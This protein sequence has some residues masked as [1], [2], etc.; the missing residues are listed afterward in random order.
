M[1]V[2]AALA[3]IL[4]AALAIAPSQAQFAG[5]GFVNG[6]V[7]FPA[8]DQ[9][10]CNFVLPTTFT[11]TWYV[12][13]SS[14]GQTQNAMTTAGISLNPTVTPHQGDAAHPWSSLQAVFST[15]T[16]Y[17][18]SLLSTAVG[19]TSASP[20]KPGDEILVNTGAGYGAVV[21]GGFSFTVNNPSYV[22][23]AA[24]PGQTPT[25]SSLSILNSTNLAFVGL[26]V[27]GGPT[28]TMVTIGENVGTTNNIVLDHLNVFT[29]SA[30]TAATYTTAAQ[31]IANVGSALGVSFSAGTCIELSN[32]HIFNVLNGMAMQRVQGLLIYNNEI[33]HWGEDAIDY[34]SYKIIISS[35]YLHD[36]ALYDTIN[37]VHSDFMQGFSSSQNPSNG[38]I[39]IDRNTEIY[40]TDPNLPFVGV[41]A[42]CNG[43][44]TVTNDQWAHLYVTNNLISVGPFPNSLGI[45]G[46][47]D[48]IIANNTVVGILEITGNDFAS[49]Q[50]KVASNI[51][52]KNNLSSGLTCAFPQAQMTNNVIM[53]GITNNT[54]CF[55]GTQTGNISAAGTYI[56]GNI[57]DSGGQASEL[58]DVDPVALIYNFHLLST[59]PAR[60]AGTSTLP[61]PVFDN[62]GHTVN[63]PPDAG[64]VA[65]P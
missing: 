42:C 40:Q 7:N 50:I 28:T 38:D 29:V 59:A 22:V 24:A 8:P 37:G 55:N 62:F 48:C 19:G 60:G 13:S 31:W 2:R 32:S 65:Y 41:G 4:S 58:T 12:D 34:E 20:I 23:V 44:I 56:G 36:P 49:G 64:G 17:P 16:G 47:N 43:G 1:N 39:W 35:N 63:S 61:R 10:S 52:V 11:H 14:A 53:H 33:D 9:S 54:V 6:N 57:I 30:A 21:T 3:G 15:V 5:T 26:S 46:C 27:Q 45:G 25:L 18:R 51:I